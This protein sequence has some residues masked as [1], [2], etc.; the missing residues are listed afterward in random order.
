MQ[1]ILLAFLALGTAALAAPVTESL[2]IRA[3]TGEVVNTPAVNF[4]T[5]KL[6]L[7]GTTLESTFVSQ[8]GSYTG[9][10]LHH[11]EEVTP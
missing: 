9:S 8:V 2:T 6:K 11:G 10:A 1:R 3:A 7:N 5:S 4:A